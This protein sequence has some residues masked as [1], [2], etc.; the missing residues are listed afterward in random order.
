MHNFVGSLAFLT[1]LP[2]TKHLF[3]FFPPVFQISTNIQTLDMW[4]DF[5][6]ITQIIN[7]V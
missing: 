5:D 7:I 2:D 1:S 4:K 6:F 3:T